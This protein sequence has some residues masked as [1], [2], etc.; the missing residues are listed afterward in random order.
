MKRWF[1][2][3]LWDEAGVSAMEYG[4]VLALI[5]LAAVVTL[6]VLDNGVDDCLEHNLN[7]TD[8]T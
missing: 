4:L 3:F 5:G 2:G 7:G 6:G 1:Q 8:C